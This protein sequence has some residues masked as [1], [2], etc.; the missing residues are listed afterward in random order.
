MSIFRFLRDEGGL[1]GRWGVLK[2]D[3][4]VDGLHVVRREVENKTSWVSASVLNCSG[5]Q[6]PP[7]SQSS[8]P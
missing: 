5:F 8:D 4:G 3:L 7:T 6:E 2:G 1:Y